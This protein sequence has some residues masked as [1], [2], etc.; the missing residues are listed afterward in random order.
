ML[1]RDLLKTALPAAAAARLLEAATIPRPAPDIVVNMPNSLPPVRLSQFKGK[2]IAVEF[3]LTYCSHCQRASRTTELVYRDYAGQGFMAIGA[4]INP[5]GD[6]VG[7]RRDH[8]VTFPVGSVSQDT[9]LFFMQHLPMARLLLPQVAFVDRN[10]NIVEQ[11]GGDDAAFFGEAEEKNLR[12]V[13][14][15]LLKAPAAAK[16]PSKK[17]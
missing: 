2:V 9:C 13:V 4:A 16:A 12:N 5:G 11:H 15:R 1:R 7:Y 6:V 17:K 8:N 3:L 10:F 14:E